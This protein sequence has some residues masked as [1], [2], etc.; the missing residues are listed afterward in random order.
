MKGMEKDRKG[1]RGREEKIY[2][3]K[4]YQNFHKAVF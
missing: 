4:F 2:L 1:Q 3:M